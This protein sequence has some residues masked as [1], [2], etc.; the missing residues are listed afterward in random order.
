MMRCIYCLKGT[1]AASFTTREHVIPV[2]LGSFA[3]LNPTI[4]AS[5]GLVCDS[6]NQKVFSPLETIF[7]EDSYEGIFGQRLCLQGNRSVTI[8]G[9]NFKVERLAGFGDKFFD[10]MFFFLELKDG[11]I[12]PVFRNQIKLRRFNGGFRVFMPEALES[13]KKDTSTFS[14]ISADL[15]KLDQKDMCIFGMDHAAKDRMIEI[16]RSL[17]VPYKEKET[18]YRPFEKGERFML[19]E[20]MEI[21]ID[22]NIGRILSKIAFNYFAYCALQD[23]A[24]HLLYNPGFD[25]IRNF[26]LTGHGDMKSII[27]SIAEEPI[28]LEERQN[29]KR[30]LA[31]IIN[32][33][34]EDGQ[35][36]ARM[37]FFGLPAIYKIIIGPLLSDFARPHFGGGHV[38]DPFSGRI[39]QLS[40]ARPTKG[41]S[42]AKLGFGL[43]QRFYVPVDVPLG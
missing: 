9:K 19:D 35:I 2:S 38:F 8:R 41:L 36:V 6:C 18:R 22:H 14:R 23:G 4:T 1:D 27:V 25:N 15:Q 42:E 20:D 40:Q 32:V 3:P 5:D 43:F 10:E 31:H 21:T 37:T 13:I 39:L 11:K 7:R 17:G 16:L 12:V 34:P 30:L 28:L 24:Q 33:L 26:I 29:G